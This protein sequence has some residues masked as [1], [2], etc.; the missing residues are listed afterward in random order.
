MDLK[1]D[2]FWYIQEKDRLSVSSVLGNP[3]QCHD[4][5]SVLVAPRWSAVAKDTFSAA[6][7]IFASA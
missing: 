4:T 6:S 7:L 5:W 2:M 3:W 1:Q